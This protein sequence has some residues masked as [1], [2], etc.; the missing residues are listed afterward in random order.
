M[1]HVRHRFQIVFKCTGFQVYRILGGFPIYRLW[2]AFLNFI[3]MGK[4]AVHVRTEPVA[5]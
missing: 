5:V 3:S 4:N 1:L 2:R